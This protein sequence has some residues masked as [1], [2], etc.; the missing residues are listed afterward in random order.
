MKGKKQQYSIKEIDMQ[1]EG[2][3][4]VY[5]YFLRSLLLHAD[6]LRF[7]WSTPESVLLL[8]VPPNSLF[9]AE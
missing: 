6:I 4:A 9:A 5:N 2:E 1:S 3:T 8:P 7:Y